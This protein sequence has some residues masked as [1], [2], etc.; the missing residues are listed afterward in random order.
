MSY[1]YVLCHGFGFSHTYWRPLVPFLDGES[2]FFDSSFQAKKNQ[3]YIGVGH[4][5][6]FQKLNNSG[7][8]FDFLIG[9]HGFLNFCGHDAYERKIRE[10]N[11]NRIIELF[12]HN[13]YKTLNMF[14]KSCQY[15]DPIPQHID[16]NILLSDLQS[17]KKHSTFC[18]Y[19]TLI[20]GSDNDE[21]VPLSLINDNFLGVKNVTI[22]EI[23]NG[24]HSLGFFKPKEVSIQLK[25][26]INTL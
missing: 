21:I 2:L 8:K 26:F 22:A 10:Q 15:P 11:L 18:G 1:T 14:Y 20:I 5:L 19:P 12:Q 13:P 24:A 17:M 7:I 16:T 25:S 23:Q 4:S 6:G 3:H 9:L